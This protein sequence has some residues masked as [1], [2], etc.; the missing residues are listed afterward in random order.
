ME[1]GKPLREITV[2]PITHPI[3]PSREPVEPAPPSPS[4]EKEREK[5]LEPVE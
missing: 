2:I 1:I 4:R 3:A 5:E